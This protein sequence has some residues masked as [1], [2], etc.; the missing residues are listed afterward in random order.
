MTAVVLGPIPAKVGFALVV[1]K[2]VVLL[3]IGS[4]EHL[5]DIAILRKRIAVD[6][7]DCPE[8]NHYQ[9]DSCLSAHAELP[10]AGKL[11]HTYWCT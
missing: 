4:E 11:G 5:G 10:C 3:E 6:G 8:D 7:E 9:S 2:S 1:P